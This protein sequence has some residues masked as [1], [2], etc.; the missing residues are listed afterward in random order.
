MIQPR[1]ATHPNRRRIS[2]L[3]ASGNVIETFNAVIE[4][5]NALEGVTQPGTPVTIST[6]RD[7]M[8]PVGAIYMSVVN[9][10]PASLF[11]GS[12]AAW[13][14]GRVPMGC[15]QGSGLTNRPNA[16]ATGGAETHTLTVEE[17]PSHNHT[18]AGHSHTIQGRVGW[19]S[20]NSSDRMPLGVNTN[21][22]A[23][24]KSDAVHSATPAIHNTGSGH[25]HPNMQPFITCFMWKRTG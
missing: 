6:L 2:R 23:E 19:G 11:G 22:R 15:G 21:D 18:Q 9:T 13:G 16:E 4:H 17:M 8:Y 25:S 14:Q 10:S 3:N 12:W 24:T 7:F 5:D 1:I 20:T